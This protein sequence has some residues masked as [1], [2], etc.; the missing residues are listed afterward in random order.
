MSLEGKVAIVTGGGAGIG[1]AIA[2]AIARRGARVVIAD[3]DETSG[4]RVVDD[5]VAGGHEAVFQR[6]DVSREEDVE[7]LVAR[8][9]DTYGGLHL[10]CNNAGIGEMPRPI[11]ELDTDTWQRVLAVD[12]NGTFFCLRAELRHMVAHGG[13]A[14][15]NTA[16]GAG[17]KAAS[18]LHSYV[19]AKHAVVGLTRNTALDYANQGV[20]INAV[21]PGTIATPQMRSYP[22]ELQDTWAGLVPMDRMGEPSEVAALVAFLL[23]DEASFITGA[24]VEVDGGFMQASRT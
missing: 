5:I 6:T 8:A 4:R 11:H 22:Q 23:S 3:I 12:L 18:G 1:E 10:A 19:A 17:L 7:A 16:S 15:V 20:R 9:I 21:A 2:L 14:I 13:G 24:V